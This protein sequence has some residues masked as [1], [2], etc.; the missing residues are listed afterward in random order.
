MI[1]KS[2]K[3][4]VFYPEKYKKLFSMVVLITKNSKNYKVFQY[5]FEHFNQLKDYS[6]EFL[7]ESRGEYA[8]MFT[9]GLEE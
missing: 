3:D 9:A 6:Y 2:I 7:A 8:V 4:G 1:K 5:D